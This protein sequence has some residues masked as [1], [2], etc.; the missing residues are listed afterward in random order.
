M[1][2][3]TAYRPRR[4]ASTLG[5]IGGVGVINPFS[6]VAIPKILI[7]PKYQITLSLYTF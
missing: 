2:Q 6:A 3:R 5:R 4:K 7:A 1:G